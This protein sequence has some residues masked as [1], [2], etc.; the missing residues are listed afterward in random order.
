MCAK[1]NGEYNIELLLR[2]LQ[3]SRTYNETTGEYQG[4]EGWN[5]FED[6]L[7]VLSSSV[8]FAHY[9]TELDRS[10]IIYRSVFAVGH[11]DE[12]KPDALIAEINRRERDHLRQDERSFV[13]TTSM[14]IRPPNPLANTGISGASDYFR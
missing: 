11:H 5:P 6:V 7:A 12:M 2:E 4:F 10:S 13:L 9:L 8:D 3:G 1:W 14:S